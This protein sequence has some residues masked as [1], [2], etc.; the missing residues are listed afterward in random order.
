MGAPSQDEI[1]A[2]Q[3]RSEGAQMAVIRA[4]AKVAE[5]QEKLAFAQAEAAKAN[6]AVANLNVQGV[7]LQT[8]VNFSRE[9]SGPPRIVKAGTVQGLRS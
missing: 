1:L 7:E 4:N 2:Y 5:A 8:R 6:T 9:A 3:R